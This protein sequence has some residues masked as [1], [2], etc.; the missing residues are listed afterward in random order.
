M[1][2]LSDQPAA[3]G[4]GLLSNAAA[5]VSRRASAHLVEA[6]LDFIADAKFEA[7]VAVVDPAG[8]LRAFASSDGARFLTV[9]VAIG[10]AWTAASMGYPTGLWNKLSSDPAFAPLSRLPR[11]VAVG[12]GYPLFENGRLVGAVAVSGGTTEQDE[13]AARAAIAAA[14]FDPPA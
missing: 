5:S 1:A 2:L 4:A 14:G 13:A 7:S 6:A 12:G 10:K 3:G 8:T 9:D 11:V